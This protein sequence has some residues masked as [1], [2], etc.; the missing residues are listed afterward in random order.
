M[1]L[2]SLASRGG[3][4]N[5]MNTARATSPQRLIGTALAFTLAGAAIFAATPAHAQYHHHGGWGGPRIGFYAGPGYY[6][7]PPAYYYP[8]VVQVQPAPP[9]YIEQAPAPQVQPQAQPQGSAYYFCQAS[10]AYYP[11]VRECPG[12]WQQVAP[13]PAR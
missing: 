12:G 13:Q 5:R 10:N 11:Y 6:Y 2:P 9:V 8:P 4:E 1:G 3:Q 7:P